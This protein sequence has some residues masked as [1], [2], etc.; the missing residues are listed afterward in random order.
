MRTLALL[1]ALM[2]SYSAAALPGTSPGAAMSLVGAVQAVEVRRGRGFGEAFLST[3]GVGVQSLS[4]YFS[5][6]F[7]AYA[8]SP[9]S[10]PL[11]PFSLSR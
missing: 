10:L 11:E 1:A 6:R 3:R 8:M 2:L 4:S 5:L 9:L 7:Q